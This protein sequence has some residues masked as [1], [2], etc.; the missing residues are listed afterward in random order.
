MK[1]WLPSQSH[2]KNSRTI[3]NFVFNNEGIFSKDIIYAIMKVE[4]CMTNPRIRDTL[5]CKYAGTASN[6]LAISNAIRGTNHTDASRI[7]INTLQGSFYSNL[8]NDISFILDT[9]IMIKS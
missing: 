4:N 5:F 9:L 6:L 1:N 2:Y 7:Q 8:K 3:I